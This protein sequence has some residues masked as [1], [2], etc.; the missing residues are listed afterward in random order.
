MKRV[1]IINKPE[2]GNFTI[3]GIYEVLKESDY[4][5]TVFFAVKDNNFVIIEI[6]SKHTKIVKTNPL[7][8]HVPFYI[9]LNNE[10]DL[11]LF[12]KWVL[13]NGG[14]WSYFDRFDKKKLN[15]SV[16]EDLTMHHVNYQ[17]YDIKT[18]ED[19]SIKTTKTFKMTDFK[20]KVEDNADVVSILKWLDDMG[21]TWNIGG[22][23]I[24]DNQSILSIISFLYCENGLITWDDLDYTNDYKKVPL[25]E[26]VWNGSACVPVNENDC[27]G[28]DL[29]DRFVLSIEV[30]DRLYISEK[31]SLDVVKTA[32][33]GIL[34]NGGFTTI[35][36]DNGDMFI[37]T[38][39]ILENNVAVIKKL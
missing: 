11:L 16:K 32:V 4:S 35:P 20:L 8:K 24:E 30:N 33:E 27:L 7:I 15:I 31:Q 9:K 2:K 22:S 25:P 1:K 13:E 36:L 17:Y 37:L 3:G 14:R 12:E 5:G 6:E 23:L 19:L 34:K 28:N 26:Y 29:E 38:K 39:Q 10:K 18:I 21:C